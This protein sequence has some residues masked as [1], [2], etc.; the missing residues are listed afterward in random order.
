MQSVKPRFWEIRTSALA[1]AISVLL[2]F[3]LLKFKVLDLDTD[4]NVLIISAV[5]IFAKDITA[6]LL[7]QIAL[8]RYRIKFLRTELPKLIGDVRNGGTIGGG[9][10]KQTLQ[11][12]TVILESLDPSDSRQEVAWAVS[13]ILKYESDERVRTFDG[14]AQEVRDRIVT[15]LSSFLTEIQ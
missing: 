13:T 12:L 7:E 15:S 14:L 11:T 4:Y 9:S 10:V 2:A 6:L 1:M 3:L 5:L 8:P